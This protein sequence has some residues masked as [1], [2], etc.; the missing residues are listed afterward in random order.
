MGGKI[1][2]TG[3]WAEV[4]NVTMPVELRMDGGVAYAGAF[5]GTLECVNFKL[6]I[7]SEGALIPA[8]TPMTGFPAEGNIV[9]V[10][11]ED[12]MTVYPYPVR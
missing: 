9:I 1:S 6:G 8:G 12:Q 2:Y 11:N 3:T 10:S 4:N 5:A 7:D